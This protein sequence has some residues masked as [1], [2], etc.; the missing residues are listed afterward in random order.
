MDAESP[1]IK[2]LLELISKCP[3]IEPE[4]WDDFG[5]PESFGNYDDCVSDG[6]SYGKWSVA[7]SVRKLLAKHGLSPKEQTS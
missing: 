4:P 6:I 2:E 7:D 5:V 3:K 1:F